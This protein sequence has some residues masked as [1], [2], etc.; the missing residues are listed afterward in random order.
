MLNQKSTV[1][2]L[3]LYNYKIDT[4]SSINSLNKCFKAQPTLP[5]VLLFQEEKFLGV[6]TQKSFWQYMSRPYSVEL[7]TKRKINNVLD[8][9]EINHPIITKNVSVIEAAESSLKR[10]PHLIDRPFVVKIAPGEYRLL[11]IHQLL[12]GYSQIYRLTTQLLEESNQKL[13]ETN[14]KLQ[15]TLRMDRLT[16]LGNE[17]S[18]AECFD[19]EWQEAVKQESWLSLI[20]FDLDLFQQDRNSYSQLAIN[21]CLRK[22]GSTILPLLNEQKDTAIHY[23]EGRFSII[24]PN[25]NTIDA[26][27]VSDRV[28]EEIQK[29]QIINDRTQKTKNLSLNLGIASIKPRQKDNAEQLLMAA[30][31]CI[32]KAKI[33]GKNCKIIKDIS[34]SELKT[35]SELSFQRT[36]DLKER[37]NILSSIVSLDRERSKK[38]SKFAQQNLNW[39]TFET[40]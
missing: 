3:D 39:E 13:A 30:E 33:I 20:R 12:L 7:S 35:E 36:K 25:T 4:S 38:S 19:R 32:E 31:E 5:G 22:I 26:T 18:F 29:L 17:M 10:E 2:N 37:A 21:G 1:E 14:Q 9:F 6:I 16:E 23:G 24:M 27:R 11:D 8:F 28:A 34:Y 40:G 15:K